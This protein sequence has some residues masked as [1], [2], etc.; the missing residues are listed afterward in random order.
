M[1]QLLMVDPSAWTRWTRGGE[2]VPPHI[3]RMLTWYLALEDKYPAL[4]VNFWLNTVAQVSENSRIPEIEAQ[5]DRLEAQ[6]SENVGKV[7][8]LED[9][10]A[11]VSR[12]LNES[13]LVSI[14]QEMDRREKQTRVLITWL[15]GLFSLL[16]FGLAG[17]VF[18]VS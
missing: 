11:A 18:F 12:S 15:V 16:V 17:L 5:T 10:V 1:A 6:V 8:S 4:D 14:R 3:Y 9:K 2:N 7:L 13:F